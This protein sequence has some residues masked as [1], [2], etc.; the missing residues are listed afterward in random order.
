MGPK[1]TCGVGKKK[2]EVVTQKGIGGA[3]EWLDGMVN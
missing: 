1:A 2:G 3:L